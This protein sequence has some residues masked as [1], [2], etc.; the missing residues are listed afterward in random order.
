MAGQKLHR[1]KQKHLAATYSAKLKFCS[2]LTLHECV[3]SA[4]LQECFS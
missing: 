3:I 2:I 1:K 4:Q